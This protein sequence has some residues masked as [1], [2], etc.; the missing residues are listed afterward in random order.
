[1]RKT[2][3]IKQPSFADVFVRE[4]LGLLFLEL[5]NG[6]V[7]LGHE[8]RVLLEELFGIRFEDFPRRVGDNGVKPSPLLQNLV[9]L[10]APMEGL[11]FFNIL[12]RN[13]SLF[14]LS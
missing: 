13:I 12:V 14:W 9:K 7:F 4:Q 5:V 6:H 8:G 10:E 11:E 1:M 2:A 3:E